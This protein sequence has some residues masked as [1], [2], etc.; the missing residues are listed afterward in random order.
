LINNVKYDSTIKQK[1]EN[2]LIKM[3]RCTSPNCKEPLK[4]E[5]KEYFYL[6]N[7]TL[8]SGEKK[9]RFTSECIE[10]RRERSLRD[11]HKDVEKTRE[12]D[13]IQY[14]KR[15]ETELPRMRQSYW[16][17]KE[18]R[19]GYQKIWLKNN[20]EKSRIN[21]KKYSNKKHRISVKEWDS[22]RIYFNYRC[23]YCDKTWEQNKLETKKDLHQEHVDPEGKDDLSN[24]IPACNHCNTSKHN[25]LLFEWYNSDNI[26]FSQE[27][28]NKIF[29]WLNEDY[30]KYIKIKSK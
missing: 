8:K 24:C 30:K 11:R 16:D 29:D 12:R 6:H 13:M 9:M 7:I 4:P 26:N 14:N 17:N 28:L 19:A 3:K 22:C 10:C 21:S 25:Y 27:R 15:R 18:E 5:S 1:G 20:P 23:A 2:L